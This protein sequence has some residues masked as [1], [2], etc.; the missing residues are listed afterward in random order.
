MHL[1][2]THLPISGTAVARKFYVETV[3]LN[4]AYRD[5]TRDIVF[6]WAGDNRRSMLGRTALHAPRY[7]ATIVESWCRN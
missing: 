2:E 5:P 3:G 4:L 6:L 1:Y 7:T